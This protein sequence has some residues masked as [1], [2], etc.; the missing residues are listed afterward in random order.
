M[1][2]SESRRAV[3][4]TL[5][6]SGLAFIAAPLFAMKVFAGGRKNETG[7]LEAPVECDAVLIGAGI[8]SATLATFLKELDPTLKIEVYERLGQVAGESSAPLNNAGTGHSALCELNYSEQQN[9]GTVDISKAI[10]VLEK[11]EVTKQFWSYL[12]KRGYFKNKHGENDPSIFINSVPHMSLVWGE[13]DCKYLKTRYETM[14]ASHLFKGIVYSEDPAKIAEWAPLV[15]KNRASTAHIANKIPQ[16]LAVSRNELGTDVNFGQVTNSMFNQLTATNTNQNFSLFFN[17]EIRKLHQDTEGFW[18]LA[19]T[20]VKTDGDTVKAVP[21][22]P[23]RNVKTKFVFI[24]AGGGS[25]PLLERTGIDEAKGY[26]GFPVSGEWLVC[27]NPEVVKQHHGKVYGQAEVGAPPMSVPHLDTRYIDGEQVLLFGPFAGFSMRFLKKGSEWDLAG[28]VLHSPSIS[29][30]KPLISVGTKETTI[31]EDIASKIPFHKKKKPGLT[32]YLVSQLWEGWA[33]PAERIRHLQN[34][35]PDAKAE[36]WTHMIAGQRVQVIKKAT[37][38]EKVWGKLEFG[39]EVVAAKDGTIAALLGASPGASTAVSI[40]VEVL[41]KTKF[42]TQ[43]ET[44][45]WK[46]KMKEMIPTYGKYL[47][48]DAELTEKTRA[49]THE[50][51]KLKD[52]KTFS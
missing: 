33:H 17:R 41:K 35:F 39:T 24:G 1:K 16:K 32:N 11:F 37:P 22:K 49:Y 47:A 7:D 23:V 30:W 8:M 19:V 46:S 6:L 5:V 38:A 14:K 34:F 29:N 51:L 25:L 26:G 48:D 9:D 10:G 43:M 42:K 21:G 13:D 15:M 50:V 3:I 12:V 28:S 44:D 20:E 36:D 31:P 45:A 52:P 4:K 18:H 2:H 27:K 40:M